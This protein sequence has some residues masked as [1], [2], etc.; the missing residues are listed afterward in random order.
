MTFACRKWFTMKPECRPR[1]QAMQSYKPEKKRRCVNRRVT[2]LQSSIIA[3]AY[4]F[5]LVC[6]FLPQHQAPHRSQ[7]FDGHPGGGG[8]HENGDH[9]LQAWHG[10][11]K[12]L[13][14]RKEGK[15][16]RPLRKQ[17][18]QP[19]ELESTFFLKGHVPPHALRSDAKAP[20]AGGE[21]SKNQHF[22]V[23]KI[24]RS[25]SLGD[26]GRQHIMAGRNT[27][28]DKKYF[29]RSPESPLLEKHAAKKTGTEAEE[30]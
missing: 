11:S 16:A 25:H 7:I 6:K 24:P 28:A 19:Q 30:A 17:G 22:A 5:V 20:G 2:T 1:C 13:Q 21:G 3:F 27:M 26:R 18:G 29:E 12:N 10:I 23:P 9:P 4:F 15:P 14:N 8:P